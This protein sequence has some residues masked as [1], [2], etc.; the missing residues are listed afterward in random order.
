MIRRYLSTTSQKAQNLLAEHHIVELLLNFFNSSNISI[1]IEACWCLTNIV[2]DSPSM[3][4]KIV[5]SNGIPVLL[6]ALQS[7]EDLLVEQSLWTIG[8]MSSISCYCR[9]MFNEAS[10]ASRLREVLTSKHSPTTIKRCVWA[11]TILMHRPF[12]GQAT[13]RSNLFITELDQTLPY[14]TRCLYSADTELI[15]CVLEALASLTSDESLHDRLLPARFLKRTVE[16][17]RSHSSIS[18]LTPC[19]RII[20]HLFM[21]SDAIEPIILATD[22]LQHLI[23]I[24]VNLS[25]INNFQPIQTSTLLTNQSSLAR[26]SAAPSRLFQNHIMFGS[27]VI[28]KATTSYSSVITKEII[29]QILWVIGNASGGTHS[30]PSFFFESGVLQPVV[31]LMNGLTPNG[32]KRM[33]DELWRDDESDPYHVDMAHD[34]PGSSLNS[35]ELLPLTFSGITPSQQLCITIAREAMFIVSNL[36]GTSA[37]SVT[38]MLSGQVLSDRGVIKDFGEMVLCGLVDVGRNAI[39]MDDSEAIRSIL[40]CLVPILKLHQDRASRS[41]EEEIEEDDQMMLLPVWLDRAGVIDF[42][43]ELSPKPNTEIQEELRKFLDSFEEPLAQP[44]TGWL[45]PETSGTTSF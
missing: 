11:L 1:K 12:E 25:K 37:D 4:A 17:M 35:E 26:F 8:N 9:H 36:M 41:D 10:T 13:E 45:S 2:S 7:T 33:I 6:S 44:S 31:L 38:Q 23:S 22:A 27:P 18:I 39:T 32:E 16:I 40:E 5:D 3:A 34:Q 15:L 21:G 42:I 28:P 43:C 14:F 20:G 19:L 29:R 24:L 30:S